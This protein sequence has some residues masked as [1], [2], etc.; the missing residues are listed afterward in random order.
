MNLSYYENYWDSPE[1]K[2]E[3]ISFLKRLFNLDL[4]LWNHLGY[5][6]H[7]Y[8][9]FSFF[10]RDTL[11]ANVCVYSMNMTVAGHSRRIAQISAV[12]TLPEYRRR[13]LSRNLMQKALD[14]A[15]ERHDFFYLFADEEAFRLYESLGFRRVSEHKPRI[16][17]AG[18][19][20]RPGAVTIDMT[21]NDHRQLVEHLAFNREPVSDLLGVDNPKLLMFWCLYALRDYVYYIPDLDTLIMFKREN[22]LLII[23]DIVAEH[24]PAFD[25]IYPYISDETDRFIEFRFLPDKLSIPDPNYIEFKDNSTHLHGD[26]PLDNVPFIFPLTSQA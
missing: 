17:A 5:W 4:S 15:R 16:P 14:W 1:R 2:R 18:A 20:P 26:F 9:P 3:F 22:G 12:G 10:D 11:A 19:P 13:G 21:R 6:D 24:M 7:R 25:L 23:F 8:R